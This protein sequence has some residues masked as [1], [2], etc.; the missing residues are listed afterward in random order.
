MQGG[1]CDDTIDGRD[2]GQSDKGV[3]PVSNKLNLDRTNVAS[4]SQSDIEE[5]LDRERFENGVLSVKLKSALIAVSEASDALAALKDELARA[6]KLTATPVDT[7]SA[8]FRPTEEPVKNASP[9]MSGARERRIRRSG[10]FDEK[11]FLSQICSGPIPAN[12]VR[13]YLSSPPGSGF[14]PHPLFDTRWYRDQY[15]DVVAAGVNPLL[16]YVENGE[17]EGRLPNPLFDPKWYLERNRD[18]AVA[19][20]S[21]LLHYTRYG[22]AEGR[23]PHPLFDSDWYWLQFPSPDSLLPNPL[24]HYLRVGAALDYDPHPLFDTSFYRSRCSDLPA[25]V[26]PLQHYCSKRSAS[27]HP[28]FDEAWYRSRYRDVRTT[29]LEDYLTSGWRE[30][31]WPNKDFNGDAYLNDRPAVA[32]RGINP[33]LHLVLS[34]GPIIAENTAPHSDRTGS[35]T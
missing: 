9:I 11:F 15:P 32:K 21:P 16:H 18:V 35:G 17:R 10:L 8:L 13:S 23:D 25:N 7:S 29:A 31:R 6:K 20:I 5:K 1:V 33:L 3:Q 34:E 19:K 14:D 27:P 28:A 22:A 26:N 12:P 4:T 24:A 2:S 30:G